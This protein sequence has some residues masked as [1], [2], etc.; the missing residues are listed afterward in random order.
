MEKA[1]ADLW[2]DVEEE[3]ERVLLFPYRGKY[4]LFLNEIKPLFHI[5]SLPYRVV[6]LEEEKT[7]MVSGVKQTKIVKKRYLATPWRESAP[8]REIT[9]I[10]YDVF[11]YL[12]SLTL[13][14]NRYWSTVDGVFS[15]FE[16]KTTA[17]TFRRFS[18][19]QAE[20]LCNMLG[21]VKQ[22]DMMVK[23]GLFF[24]PLREE[25]EEHGV[26]IDKVYDRVDVLLD[27]AHWELK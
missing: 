20:I 23:L 11:R 27:M 15:V 25:A 4:Q 5:P 8:M 21:L 6:V 2:D 26:D 14:K 10:Q 9:R 22:S 3:W 18:R 17:K 7:K 16:Y 1:G 13:P 19:S 12:F 24:E